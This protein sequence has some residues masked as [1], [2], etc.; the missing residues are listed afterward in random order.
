MGIYIYVGNEC[1]A[2]IESSMA[3]SWY[4]WYWHTRPDPIIF[5]ISFKW[6]SY[7]KSAPLFAFLLII[8]RF[9][10]TV[11]YRNRT[12]NWV[13]GGLLTTVNPSHVQFTQGTLLKHFSIIQIVSG[14][15]LSASVNPEQPVNI[16]RILAA[17]N[18]R[19]SYYC[20]WL[21]TGSAL[22]TFGEEVLN[23]FQLRPIEPDQVNLTPK[24]IR[25]NH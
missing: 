7:Q 1:Q 13:L 14:Q 21:P 18:K 12:Y 20:Q 2:T 24:L 16:S 5:E 25:F 9:W 23:A 22:E 11:S 3:E 15:L 6:F 10:L 8:E 19:C 4:E 17:A